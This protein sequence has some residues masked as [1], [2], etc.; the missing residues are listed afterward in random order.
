MSKNSTDKKPPKAP[1]PP[2]PKLKSQV[3]GVSPAT[4]GP[5]KA[6]YE[7]LQRQCEQLREANQDLK[8]CQRGMEQALSEA[9]EVQALLAAGVNPKWTDVAIR[10]LFAQADI[11]EGILGACM[12]VLEGER[13]KAV[14]EAE[15]LEQQGQSA[16][17]TI[18]AA[19]RLR[20]VQASIMKIYK[21]AKGLGDLDTSPKRASQ[22][23]P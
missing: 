23:R 6:D 16:Q 2:E 21:E 15:S 8:V 20:D 13:T 17:A 14:L 1:L 10:G 5:T 11:R 4:A 3:S 22:H 18:G 12:A 7:A 9:E 19:R